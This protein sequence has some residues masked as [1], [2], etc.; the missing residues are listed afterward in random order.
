MQSVVT[1]IVLVPDG[2]PIFDERGYAVSV[3]DDGA[4]EFLTIRSND[5]AYG[6]I[7]IDK[8]EWKDLRDL[9]DRMM[10]EIKKAPGCLPAAP[11]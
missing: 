9:V 1:Q 3:E 8:T 4:G 5:P 2:S 6:R 7:A 10:T 11:D